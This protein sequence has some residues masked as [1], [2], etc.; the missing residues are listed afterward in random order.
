MCRIP[1][2]MSSVQA[3]MDLSL[4]RFAGLADGLRQIHPPW[5][6]ASDSSASPATVRFD[7]SSEEDS[8][9][10]VDQMSVS[11]AC[12]NLDLFGGGGGFKGFGGT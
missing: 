1:M 12:L 7:T 11:S 3:L 5:S 8:R 9:C 6:I 4:P 10:S 2:E